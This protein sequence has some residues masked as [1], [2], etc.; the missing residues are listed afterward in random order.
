MLNLNH[1]FDL[2]ALATRR[3]VHAALLDLIA[4]LFEGKDEGTG[5][6]VNGVFEA[7]HL[8]PHLHHDASGDE[9]GDE[10]QDNQILQH[11]RKNS[12]KETQR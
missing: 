12:S 7:R 11:D 8:P 6:D 3:H 2:H 4:A 9:R 5:Q 10:S 1:Q